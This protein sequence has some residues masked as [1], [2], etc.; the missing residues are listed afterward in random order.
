VVPLA[1]AGFWSEQP[2]D[3]LGADRI[4]VLIPPDARNR[5]VSDS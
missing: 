4:A 1:D 3:D 2:T 5:N